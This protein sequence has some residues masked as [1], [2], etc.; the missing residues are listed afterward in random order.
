MNQK[1]LNI[2]K[3]A[4]AILT[5][6]MVGYHSM[7]ATTAVGEIKTR[8]IGE[9]Q[10]VIM[11]PGLTCD[12]SVW[13]DTVEA[14]G[15]GYQYHIMTLPGFAGNAPLEDLEAGFFKQVEA[16]VLDYIDENKIKKP[17]IIGHSLG[18]FMAL[19]IAIKR[20]SLPSKLVIVDSLPFL[21]AM[22]MPDATEESAKGFT[23]NMKTQMMASVDQSLEQRA[24]YQRTML[25]SMIL[26]SANIET[27]TK[28]SIDSDMATIAQ[29]MYELYTT[30]LREDLD[31][32]IAPT[33]VLGAWVAYKD[34]G[35]TR[36][37]TLKTYTDQYEKHSN[38]KV[39]MTDIGNHFIMWDDPEFF[40]GWLKKFL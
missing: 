36:E 21:T 37:G 24:T 1:F 34:Y 7:Y 25:K 38:V 2:K 6:V 39:D 8:V 28:W 33:L 10:P 3:I 29:S 16:M 30:D 13:D 27:A 20:P 31:K 22:Q 14:M 9:G 23:G 17:I 19:K 40:Y 26:D 32:I 12:G 18:G 5:F 4:F 15:Q 11:I 35:N